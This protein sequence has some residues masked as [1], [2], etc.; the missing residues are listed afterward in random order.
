MIDRRRFMQSSVALGAALATWSASSSET[1][2]FAGPAIVLVDRQL[3]GSAAF[4]AEK[5]SRG[6][7]TLEFRGDVAGLWMREID[8]GC[9]RAPSR[10]AGTRAPRRCSASTFSR[11][12]TARTS[13][14]AARQHP[15]PWAG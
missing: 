10:L 1:G 13:C 5:R 7:A 8:R 11:A 4:I 6:L 3:A 2:A 12:T 15:T 14:N 9:A